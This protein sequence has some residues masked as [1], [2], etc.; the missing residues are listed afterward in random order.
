ML[1]DLQ[2]SWTELVCFRNVSRVTVWRNTGYWFHMTAKWVNRNTSG[3][4]RINESL[5]LQFPWKRNLTLFYDMTR[6]Y[7]W[8]LVA[9]VPRLATAAMELCTDFRCPYDFC[10][11]KI[12]AHQLMGVTE[13]LSKPTWRC[14]SPSE[15][16]GLDHGNQLASWRKHA[17][18]GRASG[19]AVDLRG[20]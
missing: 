14:W 3:T 15:M 17:W 7:C 4:E 10:S 11:H 16:R 19:E 13:S 2:D 12:S 9:P 18:T 20:I 1:I 6:Y 8:R 5:C